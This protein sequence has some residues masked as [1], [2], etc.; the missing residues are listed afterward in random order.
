MKI[1]KMSFMALLSTAILVLCAFLPKLTALWQDQNTQSVVYGEKEAVSLQ[2]RELAPLEKLSCILDGQQVY[3][4][5]ENASIAREEL[6]N[7]IASAMYPYQDVG[8]V[9]PT[10]DFLDEK[11]WSVEAELVMYYSQKAANRSTIA[12][13]VHMESAYYADTVLQLILDHE[14]GTILFLDFY[15]AEPSYSHNAIYD[16]LLRFYLMYFDGLG[17]S[18]EAFNAVEAEPVDVGKT[19]CM[20]EVG[21]TDEALGL[22]RLEFIADIHT[23]SMSLS[24]LEQRN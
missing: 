2:I 10:M 3:L 7:V 16:A 4:S 8:L 22:M 12:W 13:V 18:P 15:T 21:W 17:V 9:D 23:L 19:G 14:T 1:L 24:I 5:D 11:H 6:L 20:L